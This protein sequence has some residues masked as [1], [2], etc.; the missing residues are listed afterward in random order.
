MAQAK[1]ENLS[2]GCTWTALLLR[3]Y[4]RDP[5]AAKR[6]RKPPDFKT[7]PEALVANPELAKVDVQTTRSARTP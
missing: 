3:E 2:G 6:S 4:D 5:G 1:P 7:R